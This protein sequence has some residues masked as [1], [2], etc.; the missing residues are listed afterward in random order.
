MRFLPIFCHAML[1]SDLNASKK[2]AKRCFF[3]NNDYLCKLYKSIRGYEYR[4]YDT[5][6]VHPALVGRI[7]LVVA[8]TC[9]AHRLHGDFHHRGVGHHRICPSVQEICEK[10]MT[11]P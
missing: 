7:V 8:H 11:K 3:T 6:C 1:F 10:K 9:C 4:K 2:M 5:I